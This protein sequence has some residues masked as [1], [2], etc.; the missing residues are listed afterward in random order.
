MRKIGI[1]G[2]GNMGI[3]MAKNL[4]KNSKD[5]RVLSAFKDVK[6]IHAFRQPPNLLRMISNSD[7]IDNFSQNEKKHGVTNV[8]INVAKFADFIY[9]KVVRLSLLMVQIGKL[10]AS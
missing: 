5:E 4:I 8:P 3:S 2:L 10:D 1:I 6:L 9:R 7:F